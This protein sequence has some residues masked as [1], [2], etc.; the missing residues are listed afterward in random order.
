MYGLY[1]RAASNQERPMMARVRYLKWSHCFSSWKAKAISN[2]NFVMMISILYLK[3]HALDGLLNGR[4]HLSMKGKKDILMN[5]HTEK[6]HE[7]KKEFFDLNERKVW[8]CRHILICWRKRDRN[9]FKCFKISW[10]H[11]IFIDFQRI[12][13]KSLA[14]YSNLRFDPESNFDQCVVWL[15]SWL[16][17]SHGLWT[18]DGWSPNS[19]RPKFKFESQSQI[20]IWDLDRKA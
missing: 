2:V 4:N 14:F 16:H 20:N 15:F 10:W 5:A 13:F 3:V 8:I 18:H 9:H 19:L 1:S 17:W 7:G 11:C 6:V 12:F